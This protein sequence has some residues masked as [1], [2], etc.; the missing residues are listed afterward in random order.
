[1]LCLSQTA[2]CRLLAF[3]LLGTVFN[4]E[5]PTS[6]LHNKILQIIGSKLKLGNVDSSITLY[7]AN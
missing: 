3:E 7:A 5:H 2:D 4:N 1:M 6:L